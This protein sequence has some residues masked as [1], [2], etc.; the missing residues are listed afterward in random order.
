L[1]RH[2]PLG[3]SGPCASSRANPSSPRP[4]ARCGARDR[5]GALLRRRP[6]GARQQSR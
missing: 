5:A 3:P 6:L 1:P 4:S 2:W